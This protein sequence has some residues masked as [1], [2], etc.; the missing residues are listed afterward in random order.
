MLEIGL[1]G[2]IGSGKSTVAAML[3]DRG[4]SLLDA[5][6]I[7]RDLQT[8]GTPV[9]TAMVERW[10]DRI[11]DDDGGLDRQ[12]VADIVFAD[13]DELAALNGIVHP[14]VGDEMT[15]RREALADT[16]ATVILDIPLLVESGHQGLAGV[17]V[18][19]VDPE[20]AVARL[21]AGRGFTPDDARSR[22][23]RQASREERLG[24]ADL[25]VDNGGSLEDLTREVDRAWSWIGTLE[26]PQSGS[27]V[28]QI[29]SRAEDG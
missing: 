26:R 16:D 20:V 2:G 23:A 11:L 12:A 22:I 27:G 15:R 21:V 25:V 5:D 8:P 9:F 4:A 28:P 1:T 14:A 10:G 3:V 7:V 6:A 17:I 18:V 24:R 19:D 13:A 29:G